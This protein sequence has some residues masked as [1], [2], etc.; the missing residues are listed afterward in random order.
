LCFNETKLLALAD[1]GLDFGSFD[2]R[3]VEPTDPV[4]LDIDGAQVLVLDRPALTVTKVTVKVEHTP[5]PNA[6]SF[7]VKGD[8]AN[9]KFTATKDDTTQTGFTI[10]VTLPSTDNVPF[11]QYGIPF[12]NVGDNIIPV[13]DGAFFIVVLP[14]LSAGN[15]G[16]KVLKRKVT[17]ETTAEE[18][19]VLSDTIP[20]TLTLGN[21]LLAKGITC[22][23][24]NHVAVMSTVDSVNQLEDF[25]IGLENFN[26]WSYTYTRTDIAAGT[27]FTLSWICINPSAINGLTN[28]NWQTTAFSQKFTAGALPDP[29]AVADYNDEADYE[30]FFA[31]LKLNTTRWNAS[32]VF[33]VLD[34]AAKSLDLVDTNGKWAD[35]SQVKPEVQ[36][37]VTK[38]LALA[39]VPLDT[40]SKGPV[41]C[42]ENEAHLLEYLVNLVEYADLSVGGE[43]LVKSI[44]EI[45]TNYYEPCVLEVETSASADKFHR[46]AATSRR[47][48]ASKTASKN[49]STAEKLKMELKTRQKQLKDFEQVLER[50]ARRI[51]T[52]GGKSFVFTSF[53]KAGNPT[54]CYTGCVV[55][56]PAL[57][58]SK[59]P[60]VHEIC[61]LKDNDV[62]TIKGTDEA[63]KSDVTKYPKE[64]VVGFIKFG[65]ADTCNFE[66]AK[67]S[68]LK[69]GGSY[70]VFVFDGAQLPPKGAA[71]PKK[72]AAPK[73]AMH[74]VRSRSMEV[75]Q[76]N[77]SNPADWFVFVKPANYAAATSD[78]KLR[79]QS[80][81]AELPPKSISTDAEGCQVSSKFIPGVT[82]SVFVLPNAAAP[83]PVAKSASNNA[84]SVFTLIAAVALF[85][86]M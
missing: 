54:T 69:Y 43:G 70:H 1:T 17:P 28:Y 78:C 35:L 25:E 60:V 56:N 21:V 26:E 63:I 68:T 41:E 5:I 62:L 29:K 86:F 66:R 48:E 80:S 44:T 67:N 24:L 10:E 38:L 12:V 51:A 2:S 84:L 16:T 20:I 61:K 49:R 71:P 14:V 45:L 13:L 33:T 22:A 57:R 50:E 42:D 53:D 34:S 85:V 74:F 64:A 3:F 15:S 18:T 77:T 52:T 32:Q 19:L 58:K 40:I 81:D 65:G 73:T 36:K 39:T 9:L 31:Q 27:N 23:T 30:L 8:S 11:I 59:T 46:Q 55:R 79:D 4:F 72:K 82:R 6:F 7:T 37:S 75:Q 47:S 76:T 83:A